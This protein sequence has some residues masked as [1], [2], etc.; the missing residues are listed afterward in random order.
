[1]ARRVLLEKESESATL[2]RECEDLKTRLA[3]S[4]EVAK[5]AEASVTSSTAER[6][7]LVEVRKGLETEIASLEQKVI[8][9]QTQLD[10]F[11]TDEQTKQSELNQLKSELARAS[12]SEAELVDQ[13][14]LLE[15]ERDE[16][17]KRVQTLASEHKEQVEQLTNAVENETLKAKMTDDFRE[18]VIFT[19]FIFVQFPYTYTNVYVYIHIYVYVR[20]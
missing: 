15:R 3:Q 18:E 10:T 14:T 2:V 6:N 19:S 9:L 8:T 20:V 16:A 12:A 17:E 4:E 5:S 7:E 11:N 1:M 13:K